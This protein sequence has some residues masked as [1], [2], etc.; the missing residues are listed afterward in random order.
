MES[1]IDAEDG[2]S[3]LKI[4]SC[5]NKRMATAETLFEEEKKRIWLTL[6]EK[7]LEEKIDTVYKPSIEIGHSSLY[8]PTAKLASHTPCIE[9]RRPSVHSPRRAA[10]IVARLTT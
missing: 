4:E 3:R 9:L 7:E 1:G 2:T 6:G 8:L 5:E 10:C